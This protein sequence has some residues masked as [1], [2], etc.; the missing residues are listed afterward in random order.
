VITAGMLGLDSSQS[1]E[2]VSD[3]NH[4]EIL[5]AMSRPPGD[6]SETI[7]AQDLSSLLND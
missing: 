1:K 3:F 6:S 2:L 7:D 5:N 4:S